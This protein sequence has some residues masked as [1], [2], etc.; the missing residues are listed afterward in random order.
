MFLRRVHVLASVVVAGALPLGALAVGC[1]GDDNG[2]KQPVVDAGVDGTVDSSADTSAPDTSTKADGSEPDASQDATLDVSNDTRS[3]ALIDADAG[4]DVTDSG[5]DAP[6][7]ANAIY[8][9]PLQ[10]AS[11]ICEQ[12]ASC[13]ESIDASPAGEHFDMPT[14]L[15]L[16]LNFGY[17][18]SSTGEAFLDGGHVAFDPGQAGSCLQQIAAVDCTANLRSSAQEK[19]IIGACFGAMTGTLEAGAPCKASI[20]CAPGTFCDPASDGGGACAVLRGDGGSCANFGRVF[21]T[22]SEMCSY[23]GSG[24]TGLTCQYGDFTNYMT[25]ADAASYTCVPQQPFDAGCFSN[26]NCQSML[27]DPGPSTS[28][29]KCESAE[30]FIYG[31]ACESFIVDG[32]GD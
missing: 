25:F 5:I 9:F 3:D 11:A 2:S 30:T 28:L 14:C 7:D 16:Y 12:L 22:A 32:G 6:F 31:F 29:F 17:A 20:E 1:G 8:G 26:D 10:V 24:N 18:G 19:S 23:R 13:C 4:A 15:S 21:S 27:C